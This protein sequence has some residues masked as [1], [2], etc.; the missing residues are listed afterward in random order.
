M[1]F[2]KALFIRI[3]GVV[4]DLVDVLSMLLSIHV[5]LAYHVGTLMIMRD[6]GR[7]P[8][9]SQQLCRQK[10]NGLTLPGFSMFANQMSLT[11][12]T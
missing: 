1:L 11:T 5:H 9:I 2:D 7:G 6:E 8:A 4:L 12:L 3:S 10:M